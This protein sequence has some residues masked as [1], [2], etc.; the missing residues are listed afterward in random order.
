MSELIKPETPKGF[1]DY[2]PDTMILREQLME[3]ARRVYRGYGFSPIDTPALEYSR[4]LLGKGGAE[5]DKQLFRFTDNGGRDVAMR[6]DLT[7]PLARYAAQHLNE[8]VFP[9]KRY[10]IAPVWRGENTQHGR[11]REFVQC[12]FDTLGT[13]ANASD[14]ET[15]FVINDLFE[16]LGFTRFRIRINHRQLLNGLLETLQ[17]ADRSVGVLRAIDKLPKVGHDAVVAEMT[18]DAVGATT[19]QATRVLEFAALTG[20]PEQVLSQ[21][22][23]WL[24]ANERGQQGVTKL[25]ELFRV[26]AAVGLPAERIVLDVSIARGLDYYTGTIYETF[27]DDLPKIGSVCS[28]GRYD[29]LTGLFT[30]QPLPGVGAS[31]GLDRLVAA[32]EELKLVQPSHTAAPV[33]IVHFDEHR[34]SE[35]TLLA[36]RLRARGI[37]TEIYPQARPLKKQLQ[38]ADRKGFAVAVIAGAEEF[39]QGIWQ[40]KQLQQKS[41]S[42][43]TDAE[44]VEEVVRLHTIYGSVQ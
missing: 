3:T 5:S 26:A 42:T 4:V 20:T 39:S 2:L 18:G 30:K 11:Y 6:F 25:R 38:Y 7:V 12:D 14:I 41:Q 9:F 40:I 33:L 17:L 31:L 43:A 10:H 24:G 1:R 29:N 15:L 16:A 35:Y 13:D 22:E 21:V 28:G 34:L 32:M 8:L 36:R 23:A 19:E 27:L 44:I 37:G